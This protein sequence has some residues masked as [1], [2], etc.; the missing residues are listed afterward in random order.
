MSSHVYLVSIT[1]N[2]KLFENEKN[3]DTYKLFETYEL[4]KEYLNMVFENEIELPENIDDD[5]FYKNVN[6][7]EEISVFLQ[8]LPQVHI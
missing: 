1:Y 4:V 7:E 2:T 8:R 3:F 5:E 6:N